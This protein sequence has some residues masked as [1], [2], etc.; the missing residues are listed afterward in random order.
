M[1][2]DK[3]LK[4]K[5]TLAR[6]RNVLTRAEKIEKLQE[7]GKWSDD[8][9]VMGLP[10]VGHR[11]VAVGKKTKE[12]KGETEGDAAATTDEAAKTEEKK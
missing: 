2:M 10:K 9:N 8:M 7:L 4:S 12:K 3:S 6:H 5:S 11:K 1:S